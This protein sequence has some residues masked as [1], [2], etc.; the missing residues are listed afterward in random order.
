MQK[1]QQSDFLLLDLVN[2][3]AQSWLGLKKKENVKYWDVNDVIL[4]VW[5]GYAAEVSLHASSK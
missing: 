1:L 4:L 2:T 3:F 5:A